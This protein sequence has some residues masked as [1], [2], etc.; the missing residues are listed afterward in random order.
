MCRKYIIL[1]IGTAKTSSKKAFVSSAVCAPTKSWRKKRV[2]CNEGSHKK[3]GRLT[4]SG[5]FL[6]NHFESRAAQASCW[7]QTWMLVN[8][9]V[10]RVE[11][12]YYVR[13]CAEFANHKWVIVSN[14]YRIYWIL[15]IQFYLK[16]KVGYSVSDVVIVIKIIVRA[17]LSAFR[18]D[19]VSLFYIMLE[20][21][22]VH[23]KKF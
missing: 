6:P 5:S 13:L 18:A 1:A 17:F 22:R 19:Y 21:A 3:L 7:K 20:P 16:Q 14:W 4:H 10:V 11:H 12:P 9:I 23:A 15:K 2:V 8:S